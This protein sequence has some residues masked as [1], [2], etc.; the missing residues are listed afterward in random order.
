MKQHKAKAPLIVRLLIPCLFL[1]CH[2][3]LPPTSPARALLGTTLPSKQRLIVL[4]L[5][6]KGSRSTKKRQIAQVNPPQNKWKKESEAAKNPITH[7]GTAQSE[8]GRS[9]CAGDSQLSERPPGRAAPPSG[10]EPGALPRHGV[11]WQVS[12]PAVAPL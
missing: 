8:S 2:R 6:G 5:N 1:S 12:R 11:D 10:P 4:L 3:L 9:L 7:R